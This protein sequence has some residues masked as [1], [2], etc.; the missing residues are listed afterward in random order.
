MVSGS[1]MAGAPRAATIAAVK[2]PLRKK[3]RARGVSLVI[4]FTSR[5]IVE[6]PARTTGCF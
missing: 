2:T 6:T 4:K 3:A 1:A 5:V